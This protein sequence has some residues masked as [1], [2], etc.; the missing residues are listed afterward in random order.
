MASP[1]P[2]VP[3]VTIA[4]RAILSLPPVFMSRSLWGRQPAFKF[5]SDD[6]AEHVDAGRGGVEARQVS[7]G[8]AARG[9]ELLLAA[10]RQLLERLQAVG[11]ETRRDDR[12]LLHAL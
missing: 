10:D 4:T 11:R 9:Q 2:L 5:G 3:P 8:L 1:I 7:K 12:D 6:G